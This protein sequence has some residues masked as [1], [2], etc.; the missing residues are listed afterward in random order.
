MNW[1]VPLYASV[2]VLAILV[3]GA[4]TVLVPLSSMAPSTGTTTTSSLNST[5]AGDGLDLRLAS[6]A[7]SLLQGQAVSLTLSEWNTLNTQNDVQKSDAWAVQGL[8]DGVCGPMNFPFGFE[9]LS[10]DYSNST[11]LSS[12]PRVLLYPPGDYPCPAI[13]A[14]IT[15]YSFYPLSDAA[16]II[17]PC[18]SESGPCSRAEM[19]VNQTVGEYWDGNSMAPLAAGAYTVVVGDEWGALLLGHF[20]VVA[21]VPRGTVILPEGSSFQ[22]SSSY[23]CVAGHYAVTF[24][25]QDPSVFSGSFSADA[26][27]VTLYVATELQASTV[28]QGHPSAWVYSTGLQNSTGFT[29]SLGAGSYVA[30]IEGADENCGAKIVIPLEQLTTVNVTQ[31]FVLSGALMVTTVT[32]SGQIR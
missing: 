22:V 30:W 5:G 9:I 10:G 27:G 28:F 18:S 29:V 15:S 19:A 13:L 12:A 26:P 25:A 20:D 16:N 7:S 31:T 23:D 2:A 3:V 11:G 6:N 14:G 4:T 8:N 24:V 17:G 21:P 32:T 1:N